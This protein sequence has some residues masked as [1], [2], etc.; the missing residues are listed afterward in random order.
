MAKLNNLVLLTA[1]F[2]LTLSLVPIASSP[3]LPHRFKYVVNV[4]T[5]GSYETTIDLLNPGFY[6]ND[7]LNPYS[8]RI[9]APSGNEVPVY[10]EF[11]TEQPIKME[12]NMEKYNSFVF[13][14]SNGLCF[15]GTSPDAYIKIS[16]DRGALDN[17]HGFTFAIRGNFTIL[18]KDSSLPI[19]IAE[20]DVVSEKWSPF[21]MRYDPSK[22]NEKRPYSLFLVPRSGIGC[23]SNLNLVS[24]KLI[25]R[26]NAE[27]PGKYTIYLDT[28]HSP[29]RLVNITEGKRLETEYREGFQI[30]PRFGR[31]LS[32]NVSLTVEVIGNST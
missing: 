26:W 28:F 7:T 9:L 11:E 19:I 1:I 27:V 29:P 24:G 6:L 2:I 22:L 32:G 12:G 8:I 16:L 23:I 5:A 30:I 14:E 17:S 15:I 25:V 13:P 4:P 31:H 21:Y 3:E 20:R 10:L 18:L